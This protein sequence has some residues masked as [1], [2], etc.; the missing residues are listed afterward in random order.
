[1]RITQTKY[2]IEITKLVAK[3]SPCLSRQ[4][5]AV[6]TKNDRIISTG[7]NGPLSK[8]PHCTKCK[9][10]ESGKDLENCPALHAEVNA[11]MY[12]SDKGDT[13]YCTTR[14]CINCLKLIIAS[15]IKNII[16]LEKYLSTE[17]RKELIS[18][19]NINERQYTYFN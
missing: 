11:L 5:G 10:K 2:Y 15:G 13:I 3:R 16:Y 7:Y 19:G 4:V 18:Q 12:A 1:M 8:F 9:R 17:V 6:I 14:P